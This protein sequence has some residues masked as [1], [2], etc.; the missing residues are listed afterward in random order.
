MKKNILSVLFLIFLTSFN[1]FA[2]QLPSDFSVFKPTET[3]QEENTTAESTNGVAINY[4]GSLN[5]DFDFSF[6]EGS[7]LFFDNFESL[8]LWLKLPLNKTCSSFLACEGE[9]K[10]S[11]SNSKDQGNLISNI[12]DLPLLKFVF[13]IPSEKINT[14]INLGRFYFAD[15]TGLIFFQDVDGLFTDFKLKKSEFSFFAGYTGLANYMNANYFETPYVKE[16]N[17]YVL[18]PSFL[19]ASARLQFNIFN[20]Q[21]INTEF[22]ASVDFGKLDYTKMYATLAFNGAISQNIFY[23]LQSTLGMN[24]KSDGSEN[25]KL[26]NL[27]KIEL[28]SY[29]DFLNSSLSLGGIFASAEGTS[30]DKFRPVTQIDASLIGKS[31][32]SIL[33]A[34]LLYTIKP[35]NSLFVSLGSDCICSITTNENPLAFDGIQ[36]ELSAKWQ[37]VSDIY[38]ALNGNQF[39]SFV[40]DNPNYFSTAIKFG[41]TF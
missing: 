15:T 2:S 17:I 33:K 25:L 8:S 12:L 21:F 6:Y 29:F 20:T 31:F 7:E 35:I 39:I 10:F 34:S 32:S 1:I 13:N 26:S 9:Y 24:L 14:E 37:I 41:F 22:F 18:S 40:E 19:V 11:V 5:S 30:F 36:W 23:I 28:T 27:S 16:E 3:K 4:G 38:L